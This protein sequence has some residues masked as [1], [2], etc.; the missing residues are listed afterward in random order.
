MSV[1]TT[2]ISQ[3][4]YA[5]RQPKTLK[6]A[7]PVLTDPL[8]I[9]FDTP[10]NW[11][12]A[13]NTITATTGDK[14]YIPFG[15]AYTHGSAT[16]TALPE[17][18]TLLNS[19]STTGDVDNTLT[20][21]IFCPTTVN[22]ID[23]LPATRDV[24][25]ELSNSSSRPLT[26][27]TAQSGTSNTMVL[28]AGES[29]VNS[30]FLG[31]VVSIVSGT[32]AGQHRNISAYVG[33]TKTITVS[34]VWS[35]TPDAT[36]VYE[37]NNGGLLIKGGNTV[38]VIGG[39]TLS[40]APATASSSAQRGLIRVLNQKTMT[41]FENVFLDLNSSYGRDGIE[42]GSNSEVEYTPD[43]MIQNC[44]IKEVFS[45]ANGN[46][47]SHPG[48]EEFSTVHA[49]L[50]QQYGK[51][52]FVF[53]DRFTGSTGY[54]GLFDDP[55]AM[56]LDRVYSNVNLKYL[57][58]EAPASQESGFLIYFKTDHDTAL[59]QRGYYNFHLED[60]FAQNREFYS[61]AFASSSIYPQQL[62]S[63]GS[64]GY[65]TN[66]VYTG[67]SNGY[68]EA[69]PILGVY[70]AIRQGSDLGGA[71]FGDY[72]VEDR[73]AGIGVRTL[74]KLNAVPFYYNTEDC[75]LLLDV[76][77]H[78]VINSSTCAGTF[79]DVDVTSIQDMSLKYNHMTADNV[80]YLKRSHYARK[81]LD[82]KGSGYVSTGLTNIGDTHL[83]A[84]SSDSF[85]VYVVAEV[86]TA[87][88]YLFSKSGSDKQLALY[89]ED[90]VLYG[91]CRGAVTTIKENYDGSMAF[92]AVNWDG[93]G[94]DYYYNETL[95]PGQ[96]G[97]TAEETTE[98][99]VF[100]ASD[101]GT[102]NF[103][104]GAIWGSRIYDRA[105]SPSE[106]SNLYYYNNLYANLDG[107]QVA[108]PTQPSIVQSVSVTPTATTAAISF[109]APASTGGLAI[110]DYVYRYSADNI[111][112]S[113]WQLSTM[114]TTT[115]STI[116]GLTTATQYYYEIIP[117]N[118]AG[119]GA[120]HSGTFTTS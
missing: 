34:N 87:N 95:I 86:D 120:V 119:W 28:A 96:V 13:G 118:A 62:S 38:N 24:H 90:A 89:V 1:N 91:V 92:I 49:D 41:Y 71:L 80:E 115:S 85:F 113:F 117:V 29:A 73:D 56:G 68:V 37:I 67:I 31:M 79:G 64:A 59:T 114:S 18:N 43:L 65:V 60:V 55:Q 58:N 17:N 33:S 45:Y 25:I 57:D 8:Y 35:V 44:Y 46:D 7:R 101:S 15:N 10:Q 116:T 51:H 82:F 106:I 9:I 93:G 47:G 12:A 48:Y 104:D 23:S 84:D 99:I 94:L 52:R 112:W 27:G 42:F 88:G 75:H 4:L 53:I 103:L 72:V 30:T 108:R 83:F 40:A 32:G 74:S 109:T 2:K 98:D 63:V 81:V 16:V 66:D 26:T 54:Q 50:V 105:L 70:G 6:Y 14:I 110:L 111:T 5:L 3:N 100:G 78:W 22:N 61:L 76:S 21:Y 102:A 107:L 39:E 20:K 97:T 36:S 69:H 11:V 19:S 77:M